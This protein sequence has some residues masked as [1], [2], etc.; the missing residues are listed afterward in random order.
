MPVCGRQAVLRCWAARPALSAV[1]GGE[2]TA[3]AWLR[4]PH[5]AEPAAHR[6]VCAVRDGRTVFTL[7]ER[8]AFVQSAVVV[9]LKYL[10][11]WKT[12]M[13]PWSLLWQTPGSCPNGPWAHPQEALMSYLLESMWLFFFFLNKQFGF[14]C[15]LTTQSQAGCVAPSGEWCWGTGGWLTWHPAC[16]SPAG[17]RLCSALQLSMPGR[18]LLAQLLGCVPGSQGLQ[19]FP[20]RLMDQGWEVCPPQFHPQ[21]WGSW[22]Q[23]PGC[24]AWGGVPLGG[25]DV[26]RN[27]PLKGRGSILLKR[28]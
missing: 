6:P 15:W 17:C 1:R 11:K 20:N 28:E 3:G 27:M 24:R 26:V 25:S 18:D 2:G 10:C 23:I 5:G 7:E 14:Y 16:C 4:W 21:S 19:Q 8:S 13:S 22:W 12:E 9:S